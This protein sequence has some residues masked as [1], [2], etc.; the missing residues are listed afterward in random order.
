MIDAPPP[1]QVRRAA[2]LSR[3]LVS[4]AVL[5][6]TVLPAVTAL[7]PTRRMQ[8]AL[9]DAAT[10]LPP[11]LR[12]GVV[13]AVQVVAVVAPV[14]A[15]GVLVARRRGDAILRIVPAAALGALL[16]W[17]VTHLAMTRSR[18]GVWPQVLVGRGALVD[19][20]WPPAAYL[21]ACAAAVV[22]AGPWLEA[23]LRRT[24]W[25][26]TVGCAGLSITAAAIM[27]LEAV[28]ALALGGVAGSAVLLLAGAP[29]DRPAPQ[30]VADALVACG[31]PLAALRETPPPDQRS[32]EGAGYGAETTTGARLTVQVLGPEDRNRDLFHRLARLALLRHPSDTDAHTPLAAVEHELLMLVFAGRTGARA[33]EPVIAYPV[34]KGGALLV[35][36]EHAARPLSAFPG[37]EI[38]DQILTG[39]WTSVARLQKH[40]LAHRALR[41]EHILVEPDGASR[42]IAFARARLGATPDALG[43]DIAELLATTATRIGVPRATQCALAGLGPP[44]LATALPYLQPLA[45][46]GPARREVAR[47]DQARARAAGA[48]TKRRTVRP[49]GRPSLLRDLSAAVV[50]ATGAEPAPLAPLA[51]FTWKTIFGLVGA[52]LVLH[53]VLPQFASASAVVAALRKADWWWVLAALPVTFISQVFS[54][55]LQMGT[56]PARLPFGPTYEVQFASSFLNRITPN[57]VGGMALN[58]RYLQKTGIETGAATASVGLQSLVSAVSNAVLAAWFFAW[59]GRHHTGVHLHVPAG[60]YVLPAIALA[61]AAGGLLG[62]TPA[63]RRFLREKVWPFLRAAASTVTGVASDPAKL[64]LLVTG[65]LGLPLIQVVGLV[66][67]VRA[68]GGGLPFVQAGAVYMAARLVANAAPVP[69][70]LGALEVGLIAGLTALGVTAGAATSAVLVY[71]L[72]TFWLNVPLG[73]LAL[74]AVQRKGYA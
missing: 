66:L 54:T 35:T 15:V 27:P 63:G 42:L 22:A 31:I 62:V 50:E 64:A 29:A 72:L 44:L 41:P 36:I 55:C 7:A 4:G 13:G 60:R 18:P 67:S 37:E 58:L 45:L 5:V 56:I 17:P 1:R 70:G 10:A 16:S 53:L 52:F 6:V 46:L 47:Y 48:G 20:G 74:R 25:T 43:S 68:F 51:R 28:G 14:V 39:V 65:A 33:A 26:L 59:A 69:G 40:R 11:G 38:T 24:W 34:D 57:N 32:G 49:G 3:L 8:Q 73:A 9:L 12:D 71:R 21:A 19:A 23:R 2:D 61:L 30:A